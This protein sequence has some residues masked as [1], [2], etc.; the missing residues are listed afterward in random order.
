MLVSKSMGRATGCLAADRPN[1]RKIVGQSFG[2]CAMNAESF[3]YS[4]GWRYGDYFRP[5][6][7]I[8]CV[9]VPRCLQKRASTLSKNYVNKTHLDWRRYDLVK[10]YMYPCWEPP[11]SCWIVD[12]L[13]ASRFCLPPKTY[14]SIF[15]EWLKPT[16]LHPEQQSQFKW[17]SQ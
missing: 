12:R 5:T 7:I 17:N 13:S 16:W 3:I 4:T 14:P 2:V 11:R 6:S 10:N 15:S 8:E 1:W 9:S